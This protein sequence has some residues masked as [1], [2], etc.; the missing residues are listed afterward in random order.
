MKKVFLSLAA[1]LV[2]GGAVWSHEFFVMTD[3][4][5]FKPGDKVPLYVLSTHYFTVGEELEGLRYN[6]VWV[7]QGG[8]RTELGLKENP[9]RLWYET[10]F[11]L[12]GDA[13][14][15][16]EG[17]RVG[18]YTTRF[19]DGSSFEGTPADARKAN[20]GKTLARAGFLEKFSK[21]YINPK[22][23]DTTFSGPL[24]FTLEI[25]PLENPAN[26]KTGGNARFRVLYR[27]QPLSGAE[28]FAVYDYY[29]YKTMNAYEQKGNTDRN[30]EITFRISNPGI[31]IL[32]VRDSR[33]SAVPD[34][35]VEN[36]DSIVVFTVPGQ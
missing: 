26:Y 14:V 20:P 10:E 12:Q 29:D 33:N 21:T 32:R 2:L 34:V 24:G 23:G 22:P 9:D 28:V 3:N 13:P 4:K 35:T 8:R 36:V 18:G 15:I 30:G 27:G 19:T 6:K 31:W 11:N 1:V 7:R 5:T 17:N 25:V 16:V